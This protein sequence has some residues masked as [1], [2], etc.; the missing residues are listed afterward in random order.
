IGFDDKQPARW[1][2]KAR[3][4]PWHQSLGRPRR[5]AY[6]LGVRMWETRWVPA[7]VRP[8]A[9][10]AW[11]EA[12]MIGEAILTN[13]YSGLLRFFLLAVWTLALPHIIR[14]QTDKPLPVMPLPAEVV[15]GN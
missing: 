13:F 1:S 9:N 12:T 14:A 7:T 6:H 2:R 15:R 5:T 10:V 8:S 3:Q 4:S 11:R